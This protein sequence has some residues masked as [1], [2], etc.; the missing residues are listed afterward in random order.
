MEH[1]DSTTKVV[2]LVVRGLRWPVRL[3]GPEQSL[4]DTRQR[5]PQQDEGVS[6][7]RPTLGSVRELHVCSQIAGQFA[8]W[9]GQLG[10]HDLRSF[11]GAEQVENHERGKEVHPVGHGAVKIDLKKISEAIEVVRPAVNKEIFPHAAVREGVGE[12]ALREGEARCAP[13]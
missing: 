5:G 10:G 3:E 2:Q 4:G 1:G 13:S 12:L 7:S 8:G 6:G 9:R 11:A